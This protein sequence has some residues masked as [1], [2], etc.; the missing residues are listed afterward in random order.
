MVSLLEVLYVSF[1]TLLNVART[2]MSVW[3][4]GRYSALKLAVPLSSGRKRGYL[5]NRGH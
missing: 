5:L 1:L 3:L 2:L 4:Q